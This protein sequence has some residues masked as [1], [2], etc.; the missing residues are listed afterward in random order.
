MQFYDLHVRRLAGMSSLGELAK[1]AQFLGYSGIA[2]LEPWVSRESLDRLKSESKA[3]KSVDFGVFAGIELQPKSVIEMS[4]AVEKLKDEPVLIAVSSADPE[5]CKFACE[6]P[7]V[8]VLSVQ[9]E[10]QD[11]LGM[12]ALEAAAKNGT[13]IDICFRHVLVALRRQRAALLRRME[14]NIHAA[15]LAKAPITVSSGASSVWE[16]RDPRELIGLANILG[17]ELSHAFATVSDIPQHV[18][19]KR[20]ES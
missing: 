11:A 16:M 1:Q 19:A 17:M 3:L 6:N 5:V 7:R 9:P 8:D 12:Y 15:Q 14:D 4:E 20:L 2:V 18:I 10:Q 13:A